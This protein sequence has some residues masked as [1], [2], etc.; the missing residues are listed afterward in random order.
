MFYRLF[1]LDLCEKKDWLKNQIVCLAKFQGFKTE[2][3]KIFYD[4]NFL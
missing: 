3:L 2:F 1:Y 4:F